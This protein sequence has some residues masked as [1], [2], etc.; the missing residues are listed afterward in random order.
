MTK[1]RIFS[2]ILSVCLI[3]NSFFAL[4]SCKDKENGNTDNNE[5][6]NTD[7]SQTEKV[8]SVTVVD[9]NGNKIKGAIVTVFKD[10]VKAGMKATDENGKAAFDFKDGNYTFT[11]TFVGKDAQYGYDEKLCVLSSDKPNI[12]VTVASLAEEKE[13]LYNG[14]EASFVKD[15]S[16]YVE[17]SA[18]ETLYFIYTP[19]QRGRYK[20]SVDSSVDTVCGYFGSSMLIY[21]N[22]ISNESDKAEDG[23][24]YIDFRIFN[25]NQTSYLFGFT[26]E[27]AGNGYF[28]IEFDSELDYIP[29][30]L[31]FDDYQTTKSIEKFV[32][33]GGA[34][35]NFDV[36]DLTLNAVYNEDD[37]FYHL[38]DKNGKIIYIKL[39]VPNAYKD[40]IEKICE[41]QPFQHYVY[42]ESGKFASKVS[43]MEMMLEYFEASDEQAGIYP[44]TYDLA[45]VMKTMG[46]YLGWYAPAPMGSEHIFFGSTPITIN[47]WLFACCYEE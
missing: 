35:V 23:S 7:N 31:P 25:V 24:I 40:A 3:F 17:F 46:E 15:G 13:S 6:E 10:G 30:E 20:I 19:N 26:A 2:L 28:K 22:D 21:E 12:T 18:G 42:D 16:Y 32:Y 39:T 43:Y 8:Y 37:G 38:N 5:S 45:Y 44:L 47:S 1:K 27:E 36:T 34:L 11:L 29:S 9:V 14:S 41:T 33:S 4:T